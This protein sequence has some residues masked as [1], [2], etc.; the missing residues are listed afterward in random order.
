MPK[1]KIFPQRLVLCLCACMGV[2]AFLVIY[3][4]APLDPMSDTWLLAGY[5]EGDITQHYAGWLAFRNSPWA[6]P[7]G[8]AANLSVPDGV[9]ISYTDS[10]PWV[11]ILCKLLHG[12]LPATWQYFG[13]YTLLCFVL[14]GLA[15]GLLVRRFSQSGLFTVMA[16]A[17]FVFAPILLDRALRH[18]ALASHW[19]ILFSLYLYL[20]YRQSLQSCSAAHL[21]QGGASVR[22]A[23]FP[24]QCFLLNIL[25]IG[26]H[27]YMMPI[28]M[29]FTLLCCIERGFHGMREKAF[30]RWAKAAGLMLAALLSTVFAGWCLGV[31][32]WTTGDSREGFGFYSM[33]L[34]AI[35]NPFSPFG[36]QW[37]RFL[38]ALPQGPG[39]Y[40]GFNYMGLGVLALLGL[41]AALLLRHC[42]KT[43][44]QGLGAWLRRNALLLAAA[45]FLTAFAC[46]NMVTLGDAS[47]TI[48]LPQKLLQ[49]CGIFRSSGRMF[50]TVW[51]LLLLGALA[52]LSRLTP[53][54]LSAALLAL[55]LSVQL[56]DL[57]PVLAQKHSH[58]Q[59]AAAGAFVPEIFT[60]KEL[61]HL[62]DSHTVLLLTNNIS[63]RRDLAVLA[64]KQNMACNAALA[65]GGG[66]YEGAWNS[67]MEK[68][69]NESLSGSPNADAVYVTDSEG[70][71]DAWKQ[72]YGN[73][74]EIKLLQEGPYWFL[75]PQQN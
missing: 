68:A 36:Y 25:A 33:N 69:P 10:I 52:A 4:P 70:I 14:Q 49:L 24:W 37:S 21:Q 41:A 46:S 40:E 13:L 64:G 39:Q 59:Q 48:P 56:L 31:V 58:M 6:F 67:M 44:A 5:D 17:L 63:Q 75:I 26:L 32:G 16:S 1:K 19:L 73:A 47:L 18:T 23:R 50:Y 51:Y 2:L 3:G 12:M 8:Y 38:P 65:T 66:D 62:G 20:Q 35:C 27:P 71:A 34:N 55:L 42:A 74:S 30:I 9:I 61:A 7:L 57:S 28:T 53:Q 11:A 43:H 15:A 45:L 54:R 72:A 29:L 22:P 60:N